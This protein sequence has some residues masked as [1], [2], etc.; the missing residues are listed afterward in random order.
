MGASVNI[1]IRLPKNLRDRF[2]EVCRKDAINASEV[3]RRLIADWIEK[4]EEKNH[5]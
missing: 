5:A 3:I 1:N 4:K 2:Q